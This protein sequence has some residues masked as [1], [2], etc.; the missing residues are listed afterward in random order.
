[1]AL[2]W[3][4]SRSSFGTKPEMICYDPPVFEG[5]FSLN[6]RSNSKWCCGGRSRPV[7]RSIFDHCADRLNVVVLTGHGVIS[8]TM[9]REIVCSGERAGLTSDAPPVLQAACPGGSGV[10]IAFL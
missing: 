7:S 5:A 9:R 2:L 6:I 4:A 1:M 8:R 10:G 3:S